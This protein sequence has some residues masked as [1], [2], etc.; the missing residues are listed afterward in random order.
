MYKIH[1][2]EA[3]KVHARGSDTLRRDRAKFIQFSNQIKSQIT[4]YEMTETQLIRIW[5]D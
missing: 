3:T 2:Q 4:S 1:V 5:E